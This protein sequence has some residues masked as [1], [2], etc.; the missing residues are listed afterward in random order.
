[1]TMHGQNHIKSYSVYWIIPQA[2]KKEGPNVFESS[3]DVYPFL[4][5]GG[6]VHQ[7]FVSKCQDSLSG[8]LL[9]R[10]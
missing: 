8:V 7:E 4:W 6:A 2:L 1:M 3:G 9:G 5:V 10:L